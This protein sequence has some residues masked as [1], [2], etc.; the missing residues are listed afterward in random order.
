MED[1]NFDSFLF[2][3]DPKNPALSPLGWQTK[4]ILWRNQR[5]FELHSRPRW[6]PHFGENTKYGSR[7]IGRELNNCEE[8]EHLTPKKNSL[9][10]NNIAFQISLAGE[11][12]RFPRGARVFSQN[13]QSPTRARGNDSFPDSFPLLCKLVAL[14]HILIPPSQDIAYHTFPN[15][16]FQLF[17]PQQAKDA[18]IKELREELQKFKK[19]WLTAMTNFVRACVFAHTWNV[20]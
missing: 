3:K 12:F 6:P 4:M 16:S 5:F 13:W 10:C 20:W 15:L 9:Y 11:S 8:K 14:F 2:L 19:T 17:V 18:L 1:F 7:T